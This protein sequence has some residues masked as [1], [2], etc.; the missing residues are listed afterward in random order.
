MK[1]CPVGAELFYAEGRTDRMKDV[2]K[3]IVPLRNLS[4]ATKWA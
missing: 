2:K 3:S 4:K 1:V